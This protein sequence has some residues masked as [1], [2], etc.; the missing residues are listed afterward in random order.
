MGYLRHSG[1]WALPRTCEGQWLRAAMLDRR[2]ERDRLVRTLN[3]GNAI[4]CNDDE[5]AV[6]EAAAELVAQRYFGPDEPDPGKVA[7]LTDAM[8]AGLDEISRPLDRRD[9]DAAIWSALGAPSP[10]FDALS[11]GDRHV[12]RSAVVTVA[13]VVM[14]LDEAAVD[15]LVREA[16][17][18]A[19]E[20]GFHPPL[21]PKRRPA[22]ER[23]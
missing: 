15:G 14:E 6:A 1:T 23:R 8:A 11:P 7:R 3:S 16:E 4:G 19:F 17:R 20:R 5:P 12:L 2:D 22:A 21:A 13:S 18:V 10:G 9:A